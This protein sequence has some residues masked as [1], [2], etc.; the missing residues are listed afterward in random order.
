VADRPKI[1]FPIIAYG[2]MVHAGYM[3]SCLNLM[4]ECLQ[5]KI[6]MSLKVIHFE[7]L[8]SRGRN[9][10]AAYMLNSD[11]SHLFFV[12]TDIIF[13]AKDFFKLFDADL[14]V[15]VGVYPKKYLSEQ[16]IS[17]L[18]KKYSELPSVWKNLSTD[19][20]SE[21]NWKES[22]EKLNKGEAV[23]SVNYS[24]TGFMLIKRSCFEKIIKERPD[25]KYTN[26]I[27][28]YADAGDNFYDFFQTKVNPESKKYESED[29]G[30]CQL[31]RSVGGEI[32]AIPDITLRHRGMYEFSGNLKEQLNSWA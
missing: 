26:D 28:G 32:Y 24:A 17:A 14:E 13:D 22:K 15:A 27:D 29:Y 20:S 11:C 7:S 10:S 2:G 3:M 1:Y 31:W 8:I 19:F 25:L 18:F 23:L 9:G 6:Q 12:D 16:K 30:F 5:R 21:L 4:Y